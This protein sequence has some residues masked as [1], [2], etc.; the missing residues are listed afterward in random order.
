M[1]MKRPKNFK[2]S[3][4]TLR[5]SNNTLNRNE[6]AI[7][8][9]LIRSDQMFRSNNNI[10]DHIRGEVRIRNH[11]F[12]MIEVVVAFFIIALLLGIVAPDMSNRITQNRLDEDVNRFARTLRMTAEIAVLRGC[13][14]DVVIE[15]TPGYYTVYEHSEEGYDEEIEPLIE[16]RGLDRCYIEQVGHEDGSHQY[17][18]DLILR[19]TP[20][21]WEKSVT[22]DLIDIPNEHYRFLNCGRLTTRVVVSNRP[23]ELIEP[24]ME[25]SMT[26]PI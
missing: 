5:I 16:Q 12:T 1:A 4:L 13:H 25:V 3:D 7:H 19:A 23:L 26:S 18:G 11:G 24:Q 8:G 2:Y 10:D 17:S 6:M 21:G 15:V 9:L 20:Q 22:F 14:L